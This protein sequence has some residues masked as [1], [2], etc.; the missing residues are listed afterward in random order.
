VGGS[1]R[2][3]INLK[4]LEFP[5]GW[6]G[7]LEKIPSVGGRG[8]RGGVTY[9]NYVWRYTLQKKKHSH[10]LLPINLNFLSDLD[11]PRIPVEFLTSN[12]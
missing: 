1:K 11:N 7:F 4:L 6:K 9:N 3:C 12:F 5:E 8:G 2:K 10:P